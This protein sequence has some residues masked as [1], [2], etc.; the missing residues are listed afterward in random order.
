[1]KAIEIIRYSS[2]NDTEAEKVNDLVKSM[3]NNG[4]TCMP[5]LVNEETAELITGSQRLA[6]IKIIY[7]KYNAG[8]YDDDAAIEELINDVDVAEDVSEI[9]DAYA[10][11]R[12]EEVG[13]FDGIEYD[14]VRKVFSGTWVEQYAD[15]MVEW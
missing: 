15:Q 9:I 13:Y 8:E 1:M 3:E 5:I 2:I 12:M 14:N 10:E 6:A 4:W 11:R 7:D